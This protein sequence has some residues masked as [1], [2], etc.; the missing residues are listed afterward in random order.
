VTT[1]GSVARITPTPLP[2][3]LAFASVH[4]GHDF[5]CGILLTGSPACWGRNAWGVLGFESAPAEVTS[6]PRVLTVPPGTRLR[7]V[8]GGRY[9][10]CAVADGGR[11]YCW[12]GG[13]SG[14]LGDGKRGAGP[15]VFHSRVTPEPVL[16]R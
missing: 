12:G 16:R 6:T 3:G 1:A 14:Q 9:H 11:V 4:G 7:S 5:R 15:T 10:N 13:F 8:D 2:G